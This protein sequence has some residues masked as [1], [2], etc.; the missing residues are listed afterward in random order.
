[1]APEH[2]GKKLTV[3]A[4]QRQKLRPVVRMDRTALENAVRDAIS[5]FEDED[6]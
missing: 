5:I 2:R 3:P 1:V 4:R 6:D